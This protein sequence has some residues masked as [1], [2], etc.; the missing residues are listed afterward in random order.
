MFHPRYYLPQHQEVES[1]PSTLD[2]LTLEQFTGVVNKA[3]LNNNDLQNEAMRKADN[4][5]F[6][7]ANPQLKNSAKNIRLINHW[8]T[9]RGIANP[10]YHDFQGAYDALAAQGLLDID[11]T[12]KA[13]RTFKGMF[14]AQTFDDLDTFIA[15]ERAASLRQV[16]QRTPEELALENAPPEK[17]LEML[18]EGE[19]QEQLKVKLV[20]VGKNGDA[21]LT[22]HPEFM[23][24][25]R[26]GHLI[27]MQL[28]TNNVA[29]GSA[30][31]QD[32]EIAYKQLRKSGLL[33]LDKDV[34]LEQ[35]TEAVKQR[36]ARAVATPGSIWDKT[37]EEQMYDENLPLEEVRRRANEVLSR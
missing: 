21:W 10:L 7:T 32:L 6:L 24:T 8:L 9:S 28:R 19:R 3:S 35:E 30:T 16:T 31:I 37:T 11:T 4:Y 25:P 5:S 20:E 34:L 27:A 36:A 23:D 18:R 26:N 2:N 12:K 13:P 33:S 15:Q 29:E 1:D 17:V 14:S 22:L